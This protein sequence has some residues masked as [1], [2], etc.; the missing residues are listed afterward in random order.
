MKRLF[1]LLVVLIAVTGS[2][3]AG[4]SPNINPG[5]WEITTQAEMQGMTMPPTTTTQCL[6]EDDAVPRG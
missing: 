1:A 3:F 6:T 4:G 2:A 5:L